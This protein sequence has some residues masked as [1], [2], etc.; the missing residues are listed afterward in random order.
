MSVRM[1]EIRAVQGNLTTTDMTS[2][3]VG[4]HMGRS[5]CGQAGTLTDRVP[6]IARDA[7]SLQAGTQ[8]LGLHA[9]AALHSW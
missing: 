7:A 1:N 3:E 8:P 9:S 4:H 5:T 2:T 6:V